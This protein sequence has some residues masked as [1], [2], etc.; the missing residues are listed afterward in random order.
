MSRS[1]DDF[2]GPSFPAVGSVECICVDIEKKYSTKKITPYAEITMRAKT[3]EK[4]TDQAYLVKT[5]LSRLS[6]VASR[7]CGWNK[8]NKLSDSDDEALMEIEAFIFKNAIG[9]SAI[10]TI[11]ETE[12]FYI[13]ES[14]PDI[15]QKKSKK[16]KK[17]AFRGYDKCENPTMT[18][19][20]NENMPF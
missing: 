1:I 15:G 12:E 14:G 13:V 19:D 4:F 17:V 9:K 20:P 10:L 8:E 2:D 7:L 3:G 11:E 6:I 5:A 18:L 16:K